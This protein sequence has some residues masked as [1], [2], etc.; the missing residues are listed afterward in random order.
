MRKMLV[1]SLFLLHVHTW[2]F[3]YTSYIFLEYEVRHSLR[4]D[5]E[6]GQCTYI[7]SVFKNLNILENILLSSLTRKF[8]FSSVHVAIAYKL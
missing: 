2:Y 7:H 8:N 5:G 6:D 3:L 4:Y 1:F